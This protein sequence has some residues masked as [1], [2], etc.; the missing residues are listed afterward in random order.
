VFVTSG[1]VPFLFYVV[2][3]YLVHAI[4]VAAGGVSR[5]TAQPSSSISG[6]A[7]SLRSA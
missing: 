3:L 7:A 2:H 5:G 6:M 1:R 4:A